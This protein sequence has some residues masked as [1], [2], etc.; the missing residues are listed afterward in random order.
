MRNKVFRLKSARIGGLGWSL[1][2]VGVFALIFA[3]W[4]WLVVLRPVSLP[5]SHVE[6]RPD[7][8]AKQIT[9]KHLF[10]SVGVLVGSLPAV[11]DLGQMVLAGIVS[12][13]SAARGVAIILVDGRKAVT[14]TVG[15]EIAPDVKLS[16]VAHDHVELTHR[17]QTIN[18][19][20]VA[21]K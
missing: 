1:L 13:G 5:F 10:G 19:R 8:L 17:G 21:K 2:I 14:A 20:L 4:S 12:T 3:Y 15:Q 18:L 7:K 16:R 9:A 11:L 6:G